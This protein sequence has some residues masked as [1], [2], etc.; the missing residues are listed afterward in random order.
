MRALLSP[1]SETHSN[2]TSMSLRIDLIRR[3][4]VETLHVTT[5]DFSSQD[6]ASEAKSSLTGTF[7][8][9]CR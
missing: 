6:E 7:S 9:A 5:A 1:K 4:S 8:V 3:T 2:D